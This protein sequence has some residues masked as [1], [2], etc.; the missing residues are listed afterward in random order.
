VQVTVGVVTVCVV[1]ESPAE[2]FCWA[3]SSCSSGFIS[4]AVKY[5]LGQF[6]K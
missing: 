6:I 2:E 5:L 1:Q 4:S 3:L